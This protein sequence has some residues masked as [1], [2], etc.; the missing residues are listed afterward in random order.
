MTTRAWSIDSADRS[1]M[2]AVAVGVS[3]VGGAARVPSRRRR[4]TALGGLRV[5]LAA[6]AVIVAAAAWEGR[7]AP[8]RW[9]GAALVH[10]DALL[11]TDVVVVSLASVREGALDA[12]KLHR[13]GMVREIWVPRWHV[14]GVDRRLDALGVH[15]PRPH[16]IART[17]IERAGVPSSAVVVLEDPVTGLESEMA[18]VG[19]A[20]R[21]RPGLRALVLTSRTHTARARALLRER[22]APAARVRV[23]APHADRFAPDAWWGDRSAIRA[24]ALEA[25]KWVGLVLSV[26]LSGG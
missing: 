12:A 8:L 20:L 6:A 15:V 14:D 26:P 22:F 9:L 10:E 21:A 5:A 4:R 13:R 1:T 16:E 19:R 23:H 2:Q 11:P 24:V 17:V 3:D 7:R 25:L 18:S